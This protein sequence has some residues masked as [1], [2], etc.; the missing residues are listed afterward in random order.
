MCAW[1][2]QR[3]RPQRTQ[4]CVKY[5]ED[6]LLTIMREKGLYNPSYMATDLDS[7]AKQFPD[8]TNSL[9]INSAINQSCDAYCQSETA[10]LQSVLIKNRGLETRP[11]T[12]ATTPA[13]F[14]GLLNVGF[15]WRQEWSTQSSGSGGTPT[16]SRKRRRR[17]SVQQVYSRISETREPQESATLLVGQNEPP[18]EENDSDIL[19]QTFPLECTE[20]GYEEDQGYQ[21][22]CDACRSV[23]ELPATFFPRI[24]NELVCGKVGCLKGHGR[25]VQ[26]YLPI[27]LL[28]NIGSV[29][30]QE[31]QVDTISVRVFCDCLFDSRSPLYNRFV[32]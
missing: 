10:R 18:V 12:S 5:G 32:H 14:P 26:K 28:R 22:L 21:Q 6:H 9:Y 4:N 16:F 29:N 27:Q 7:A 20:A 15:E 19:G 2:H 1:T 23:R 30:C 3:T 17:N 31:W 13:T 11:S 8:L 25:C 24:L